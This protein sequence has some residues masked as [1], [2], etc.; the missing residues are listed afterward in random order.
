MENDISFGRVK[1]LHSVS[2]FF[3]LRRYYARTLDLLIYNLFAQLFF[4]LV[5]GINVIG[6]RGYFFDTFVALV[7]MFMFEPIFLAVIGTTFGKCVLGIHV[8]DN[9]EKLLSYR[10]AIA[11]TSMVMTFGMGLQIPI[12]SHYTHHNSY[13]IYYS[14][15]PLSW[16]ENTTC[17]LKD[18]RIIRIIFAFSIFGTMLYYTLFLN[19]DIV[20][21]PYVDAIMKVATS[22]MKK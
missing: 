22:F 18:K 19:K 11:R 7:V 10:Q 20:I 4:K 1:T 3:P 13:E 14:V 9:Y 6:V 5:L 17:Y 15:E 12:L 8:R 21:L 2:D 16:D